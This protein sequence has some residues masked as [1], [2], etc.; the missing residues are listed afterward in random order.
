MDRIRQQY[1][2]FMK[3]E[4]EKLLILHYSKLGEWFAVMRTL[5]SPSGKPLEQALQ[6]ALDDNRTLTNTPQRFKPEDGE[7]YIRSTTSRERVREPDYGTLLRR[8]RTGP[9][10]LRFFIML[11]PHARDAF[12]KG[13]LPPYPWRVPTVVTAGA[14]QK[15]KKTLARQGRPSKTMKGR[16][17]FNAGQAM[18]DGKDLDLPYGDVFEVLKKLVRNFG[19]VV[20]YRTFDRCYSSATP[21]TLPKSVTKIRKAFADPKHRVPC[22]IKSKTGAGYFIREISSP[23]KAKKRVRRKS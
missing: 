1:A 12:L 13:E 10:R 19:H 22:E 17:T 21:G 23:P 6:E 9:D 20:L 8:V 18:F 14:A 16:F 15:P 5:S 11:C 2:Q 4:E 7:S 3:D